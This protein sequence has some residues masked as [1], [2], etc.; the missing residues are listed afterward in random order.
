MA[1]RIGSLMMQRPEGPIGGRKD[2]GETEGSP[3]RPHSLAATRTEA[4]AA[5]PLHEVPGAR[6]GRGR[7][8]REL[9]LD[10]RVDVVVARRGEQIRMNA[11]LRLGVEDR[12]ERRLRRVVRLGVGQGAVGVVD[13]RIRPDL[14]AQR[15]DLLLGE[16]DQGPGGVG[17][18]LRPGLDR[19][20]GSVGRGDVGLEGERD[21]VAELAEVV[22][23]RRDGRDGP[24]RDDPGRGRRP[25]G[26]GAAGRAAAGA[27]PGPGLV[28]PVNVGALPWAATGIPR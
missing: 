15:L 25:A 9:E 10:G 6:I 5:G 27:P 11:V 22:V 14:L 4:G 20:L 13:R 8:E 19:R 17:R 1:I 28:E 16:R 18:E 7:R 23:Q 21:L 12:V 24:D 3:L 2:G 26:R